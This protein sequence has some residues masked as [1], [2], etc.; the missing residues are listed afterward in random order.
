MQKIIPILLTILIAGA[1]G[2]AAGRATS[3]FDARMAASGAAIAAEDGCAALARSEWPIGVRGLRLEARAFG[4]D[5][6]NATAVFVASTEQ[7]PLYQAAFA[8]SQVFGLA[9]AETQEAMTVALSD[10]I[11]QRGARST[12]LL[13]PWP[14]GAGSPEAGEFPFTPAPWLTQAAY[15]NLRAEDLPVFCMAQG[16]ETARCLVARE[17]AIEDI[18]LQ[19]FPG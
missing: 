2:F 15:E 13:P 14:A 18:G 19:S 17:D 16:L 9:E 11:A 6:D 8:T 7:G 1:G 10:W 4:P 3:G 5:C 12:A